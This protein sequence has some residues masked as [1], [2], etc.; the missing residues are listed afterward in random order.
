MRISGLIASGIALS[1]FPID[2]PAAETTIRFSVDMAVQIANGSFNPASDTLDVRGPFNDWG[3]GFGVLP[4]DYLSRVGTTTVFAA[5]VFDFISPP[6]GVIEYKFAINAF[7]WET[8]QTLNHNRT[9]KRTG[10]LLFPPTP[11]FNDVG[12]RVTNQ[13]DLYVDMARLVATGVFQPEL[14]NHRVFVRGT[15]NN[16]QFL[17][18]NHVPGRVSNT[19]GLI[20]TNLYH[21][22]ITMTGSPNA[23]VKFKF[24]R[25]DGIAHWETPLP[26]N[27]DVHGNRFMLNT[28]SQ[29]AYVAYFSDDRGF[30]V[31]SPLTRRRASPVPVVFTNRVALPTNTACY[32]TGDLP[33]LGEWDATRAIRMISTNHTGNGESDWFVSVALPE[34][35]GYSYRYLYRENCIDDPLC[36]GDAT[37]GVV[38]P[39]PVRSGFAPDLGGAPYTGKTIFAYSAWNPPHL[40][41]SNQLGGIATQAM[42]LVGDGRT[43]GEFLWRATGLGPPDGDTS[44]VLTDGADQTDHALDSPGQWH[45]TPLDAF[46]VQDHQVYPYW[47]APNPAPSRIETFALHP[48]NLQSRTIRVYLPRGYDQHPDKRYPVLYMHDGQNLF[49]GMGSFGSWNADRHADRLI[50]LGRMQ[51]TIIVGVDNTTDRWLEYNP[52][53]CGGEGSDYAGMLIHHLKPLIDAAYRTRPDRQHT[54]SMGASLGG[55]ISLYLGWI[56]GDVFGRIAPISSYIGCTAMQHLI[57]TAAPPQRL[58]VYIDSGTT[59]TSI[60]Y[61]D[62]P[63]NIR[64]RD[65]LVRH[66]YTVHDDMRDNLGYDHG[67]NETWWDARVPY[68]FTFI[69]PA[70]GEPNLIFDSSAPQGMNGIAAAGTGT[71]RVSW[72]GYHGRTYTLQGSPAT[73]MTDYMPWTD[74]YTTSCWNNAVWQYPEIAVTSGIHYIRVHPHPL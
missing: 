64:A 47:P 22:R 2:L 33:E 69:F 3:T 46:L 56:H 54:A 45:D 62:A 23:S 57:A 21:A 17:Q 74:L 5:D 26:I 72:I 44:F 20:A 31:S 14:I 4:P 36:L 67:H 43:P 9:I 59:D 40:V 28:P 25:F 42:E 71:P 70:T 10:P 39:G 65:A 15:F 49:Q 55:L 32:L 27:S 60:D 37:N 6:H 35:A 58:R 19:F 73:S 51:E 30:P 61:D 52:E 63:N 48:T 29:E 66:G 24:V 13:V 34:G 11:Y 50:G 12:P 41:F 8:N 68:A 1:L 16:W 38:E 53:S 18:M 7:G